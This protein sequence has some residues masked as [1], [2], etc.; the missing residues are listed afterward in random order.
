MTSYTRSGV[1]HT[2]LLALEN[3]SAGFEDHQVIWTTEPKRESGH[4]S[5]QSAALRAGTWVLVRQVVG[6]ALDT[7][8]D[9]LLRAG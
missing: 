1:P 8:E 2:W 3:D 7:L 6:G 4:H 5:G 9:V